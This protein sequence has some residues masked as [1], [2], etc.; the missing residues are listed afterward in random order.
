MARDFPWVSATG[1]SV[2]EGTSEGLGF[3]FSLLLLRPHASLSRS[4]PCDCVTLARQTPRIPLPALMLCTRW[5]SESRV[6]PIGQGWPSVDLNM[7]LQAHVEH[8]GSYDVEVGK[9]DAQPPS[10]VKEDEQ[11][12]GQPLAEDP[13]GAGGGR[14]RQPDSQTRQSRRHIEIRGAPTARPPS[15]SAPCRPGPPPPGRCSA[16]SDL[17]ERRR[18]RRGRQEGGP[19]GS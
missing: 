13:I 15:L 10:Q 2:Q 18:P 14:A 11:R 5:C 19:R 6:M 7:N 9:V 1:W 4:P 8:H 16:L 3:L 17:R 12:T